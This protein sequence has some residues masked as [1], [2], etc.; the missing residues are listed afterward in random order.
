MSRKICFVVHRY[1]PYPGGSEYYVQSMAEESLSRGYEV[2]VLTSQH[3]G[4]I[5]SVKVTDNINILFTERF[6]LV[7][8]NG[9]DV[10]IQNEVLSKCNLIN[11][12]TLYLIIKP[13]YSRECLQGLKNATYLG[14]GTTDDYE[15]IKSNGY[16]NKAINIRYGIKDNSIG[17]VGFR[18]KFNIPKNRKMFLTAGGYWPHKRINELARMFEI[19]NDKTS[20]LVTVGYDNRH[21]NIPAKT[22]NVFPL[23]IENKEDVMSA[24]KESYC[25]IMN[26]S[27]E[28]YGLVLLESMINSTPWISTNVGGAKDLREFGII[29][30]ENDMINTIK[31]F[32]PCR[33]KI[34]KARLFV[35]NSHLIKHTINDIDRLMY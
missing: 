19:T 32:V 27:D 23:M 29:C 26:S 16:I 15:Y 34:E 5:N 20:L 24:I 7:V 31:N 6:D 12:P 30:N 17:K 35:L 13:S 28:G 9:G 1:V 4:N 2:H 10:Q 21:N 25:Y 8:V 22:S 14:W 3:K 33:E 11:S 18:D